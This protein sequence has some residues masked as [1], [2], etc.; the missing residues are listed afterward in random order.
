MLKLFGKTLRTN[1]YI[2]NQQIHIEEHLRLCSNAKFLFSHSFKSENQVY[3]PENLII[4]SSVILD[5][6][7]N[8]KSREFV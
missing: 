4:I 2:I 7:S 6:T 8:P 1:K 5:Q 3:R